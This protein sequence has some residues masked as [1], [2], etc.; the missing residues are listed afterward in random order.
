ML[1]S[2]LIGNYPVSCSIV[3]ALSDLTEHD[4]NLYGGNVLAAALEPVES[5]T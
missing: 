3:V 2:F 1:E 4:A 5:M